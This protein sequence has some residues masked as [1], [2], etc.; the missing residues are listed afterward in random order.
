MHF[1]EWGSFMQNSKR[2]LG[3]RNVYFNVALKPPYKSYFYKNKIWL[4]A[5]SILSSVIFVVS[6]YTQFASLF[7]PYQ[8]TPCISSTNQSQHP[9]LLNH[10]P[11]KCI[12]V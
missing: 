11:Q 10:V 1:S 2:K 12:H 5:F 9:A 8:G 3:T 4:K 6:D 7:L